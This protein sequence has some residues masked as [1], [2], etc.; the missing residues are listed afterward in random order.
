MEPLRNTNCYKSCF[1]I[2]WKRVNILFVLINQVKMRAPKC[3]LCLS[4]SLH[5]RDGWSWEEWRTR[6]ATLSPGTQVSPAALCHLLWPLLQTRQPRHFDEDGLCPMNSGH[7]CGRLS[8]PR[9]HCW[10]PS[11]RRVNCA[12]LLCSHLLEQ[13]AGL[14]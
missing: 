3:V 12:G 9:Q 6:E 5:P 2:S 4:L 1:S 13:E 8:L 11:D 10:F 14:C 7:R